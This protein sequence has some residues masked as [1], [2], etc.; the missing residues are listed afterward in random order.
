M[1][2]LERTGTQLTELEEQLRQR[3]LPEIEEYLVAP[4]ITLPRSRLEP[5]PLLL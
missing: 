5:P 3:Y 1:Q 2:Q 4:V